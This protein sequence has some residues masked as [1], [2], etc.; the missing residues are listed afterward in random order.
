M[1]KQILAIGFFLLSF[2]LPLRAT[3]AKFSEIY[4]FGDSLSDTGNLFNAYLNATGKGLP[5]EPYYNGRFSNGPIWV[6]YLARD[7]ELTFNPNTNLAY[8]GSSTG[9]DNPVNQPLQL[10]GLLGQI[11][12]FTAPFTAAEQSV[13]PNALYIVWAGANDYLFSG[14]TDPTEPVANLST[15]VTS[16]AAVG[17]RNIMVVNLP[18][19]GETPATRLNNQISEKLS[20]VTEMHNSALGTTL[21]FLSQ[22]LSPDINIIPLDINSIFTMAIANPGEY[23]FTNVANSCIGDLSVVPI[24]VPRPPVVCTPETFFFWDEIH[25]TTAGHKL[26]GE[27]AFSALEPEP[28]PEPS[29]VLGVLAFGALGTLSRLKCKNSYTKPKAKL[30]TRRMGKML[31]SSN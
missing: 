2:M 30:R 12:N 18:D 24:D 23:G 16:L 22:T 9:F 31:G 28:V 3:A 15:A 4:V 6:E 17:A 1:Q 27:F 11:N 5:P 19:L 20:T 7:L 14:L 8:G 29:A 10:P 25:P 13:D 26:F 21:N